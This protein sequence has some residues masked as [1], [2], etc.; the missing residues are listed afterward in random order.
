[1]PSSRAEIMQQSHLY[2]LI[3][4]DFRP[5]SVIGNEVPAALHRT[6]C[7]F[8]KTASTQLDPFGAR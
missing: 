1:M 2:L 6:T 3:V 8:R 7:A 4:T 5:H